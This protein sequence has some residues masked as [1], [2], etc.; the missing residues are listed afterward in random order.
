MVVTNLSGQLQL[1][2][3]DLLSGLF[4]LAGVKFLLWDCVRLGYQNGNW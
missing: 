4:F 3:V 1:Q 2:K